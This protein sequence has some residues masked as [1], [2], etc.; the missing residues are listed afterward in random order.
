MNRYIAIVPSLLIGLALS[1]CQ[2]GQGVE[3][4]ARA[5]ED[6]PASVAPKARVVQVITLKPERFVSH[7]EASGT[8]LP[9]REGTLSAAVSGR[10]QEILVQRGERVKEKQP[11][12]RLDRSGFYLG[13]QQAEAGLVAARVG[14]AALTTEMKRFDRLLANK[15]VPRASYDKVKA[16]YDGA[17]AQVALAEVGLKQARKALGDAELRA[18]Y[19]GVITMVLKQVG[20][21]APAMPPT[22]LIQIVDTASLEV[23]VFLP[24][25]EA[26][27]VAVGK[28]AR[29]QVDSAGV[30]RDGQVIFVSDRIQPGSQ[31]F[32]VRIGLDNADGAIKSGAFAR[33]RMVRR[34]EAQALLV[35]LRAVQ[36]AGGRTAVFVAADGKARLQPVELGETQGDRVLVLEGLAPGAQLITTGMSELSDGASVAP[37]Q[38]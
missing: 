8:A 4:A 5:A 12:L 30:T 6:R 17:A 34:D 38:G 21:Y 24:E 26:R 7:V 19:D 37:H 15:A 9:V 28:Q 10:I 25:T 2:P 13:V 18:P 32:E 23:Q 20:E 22:M 33:V 11:L 29:V 31:T 35:P 1:A 3:S 27:Q 16:Q 14:E 36:R